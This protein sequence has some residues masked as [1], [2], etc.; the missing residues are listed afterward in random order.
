MM[1][2][3][4]VA[5]IPWPYDEV[6]LWFCDCPGVRVVPGE[7][8]YQI[9]PPGCVIGKYPNADGT[10][11][12]PI[13]AGG[14]CDSVGVLSAGIPFPPRAVASFDQDGDLLVTQADLEA[15]QS[16]LSSADPTADFDCDGVV[17]SADLDIATA[18]L[19]HGQTA[20]DVPPGRVPSAFRFSRG[21]SPNPSRGEVSFAVALPREQNLELFIAD[22]SGRRLAVLWNGTSPAGEHRFTWRPDP[23]LAPRIGVGVFMIVARSEGRT[24]SGRFAIIR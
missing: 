16:K 11:L 2:L 7:F 24:L 12:F 13:A 20:T 21:P 22:I 19:G 5:N 18:H 23:S 14:V 9:R 6:T 1:V 15:I 8:S 17:T 10:V 3:R 4:N